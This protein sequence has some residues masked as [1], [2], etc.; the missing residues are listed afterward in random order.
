MPSGEGRIT[1]DR[2]GEWVNETTK[3][4]ACAMALMWPLSGLAQTPEAAV[5][6]AKEKVEA[7]A[8]K[9][10][11]KAEEAAEEAEE[12]A[13]EA[14]E[15][16]EEAE[17]AAEEAE[18]AAEEAEEAAEEA[19]EA[20][21]EAA[22][23]AEEAAE[24][25]EGA[26]EDDTE[27]IMVT[28]SR[29][30]RDNL[31]EFGHIAVVDADDIAVSGVS[32]ID[33]LLRKLPSVT[34]QGIN[35]NNNNGGNGLSFID[36]RNLGIQ[37]TLVLVNGRR[38]VT[39][40]TGVSEAVDLNNIPV[41]MIERVEVLLDGAS[42]IY[43]SDAV[44]G[45]V[46]IILK[47]DFEGARVD[48]FGGIT[49]HGDGSELGASLTLGH[50]FDKGNI[51]T[52]FTFMRRGHIAQADRDWARDPV[53]FAETADDGS[54]FQLIGSGAP[55]YGR[56]LS[57]TGA[58]FNPNDPGAA[59]G[60]SFGP[61]DPED[62][63]NYGLE[64]WL[65]GDTQRFAFTTLA[66]YELTDDAELFLETTYTNR[67]SRNQLA[68]QPVGL[69][70]TATFANGF[71]VPWS[72][73][74]VPDDFRATVRGIVLDSLQDAIEAGDLTQEEA[75]MQADAAVTEGSIIMARRMADVGNRI[76]DTESDVFRVVGGINGTV[77]DDAMRWELYINYGRSESNQTIRNSVNLARAYEAADPALCSVNAHRGCVVGDFF[78]AQLQD[79]V[80]DYIRFTDVEVTGYDHFSTGLSLAG[81]IVELWAGPLGGAI[82]G[83]FRRESGFNMPGAVTV[84]GDSAGNGIGL[85]EG[86]YTVGAA[87]AELSLP[88]ASDLPGAHDVTVDLA[89]RFANY[90]TF[91]NDLTTRAALSY[92]PTRDIRL[93]GVYSTAF[94]AP[95]ISD[96]FG[97]AAD[98]YETL[99]D[100][101]NE[102]GSNDEL[103][104]AV[105]DRCEAEGVPGDYNQND[106]GGSQMRTNI[107]GN[108]ALTAE[109]ANIMNV[110]VVLTPKFNEWLEGFSATVDYYR[111][112]IS[113]AI[114]N[115]D[116]QSILNR[117]YEEGSA[118]DCA[119]ITRNQNTN[120]VNE[121]VAS[122]QNIGLVETQG[123]D[124][125]VD[126]ILDLGLFGAPDAGRIELGWHANYLMQYDETIEGN[127]EEY[128]GKITSNAGTFAQWR[129]V[130][131]LA[132]GIDDLT[133]SVRYR[134]IGGA[135]VFPETE[136]D[137]YPTVDAIGYVDLAIDYQYEDLGIIVGAQNLLD[138]DPPFFLEG[139]QNANPESYNFT[140]RFVFTRL[141]YDF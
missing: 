113:N 130:A 120:V 91:G 105:K 101:C 121:L 16:A 20:A 127:T 137:P 100:P 36:L 117:C 61:Y 24:Q 15:A 18:E 104:Q 87:F 132:Y 54:I 119:L 89:A 126:Y 28:G 9:A 140:G 4:V 29:I 58:Y 60:G 109:T 75:E 72:N 22:E 99:T 90:S 27:V 112:D 110:G 10:E 12:A 2:G 5:E 136:G 67:E 118:E 111:V 55:I 129:W 92:A 37:R 31:E 59:P 62:R 123:L 23:Q 78:G 25:A 141:S 26:A 68:P 56:D 3:I 82:G 53:V 84:A 52:N 69:G 73:P 138:T 79:E 93:R 115:P 30:G 38:F 139:G 48:L 39:N 122:A 51:T 86:D 66:R 32:T 80:L 124:I 96:L 11:E 76:T 35:K 85:T 108:E 71:E 133:A 65:A 102:W 17:E 135:D 21:E 106:A 49:T 14:E 83:E 94:R 81:D 46:N 47:R 63:Y 77:F 45:V 114:T 95:T 33:E 41:A 57:F 103:P 13:D 44:G 107:G 64:Q 1:A 70:G 43:G 50:T 74:Y 42:A 134:H 128:A 97:G 6:Q 125:T 19:E 116:P 98:S 40:G 88:L 131:R 34:L 7:A 8:E